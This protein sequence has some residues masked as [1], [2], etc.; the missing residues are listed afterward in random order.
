[1]AQHLHTSACARSHERETLTRCT[2]SSTTSSPVAWF[3]GT[4]P[5]NCASQLS[6]ISKQNATLALYDAST[7]T[8]YERG[9]EEISTH[10]RSDAAAAGR[11]A[12]VAEPP[13]WL[14]THQ[15]LQQMTN[16]APT[17]DF[18]ET[19]VGQ[20]DFIFGQLAGH[21]L[22]GLVDGDRDVLRL[23][24]TASRMDSDEGIVRL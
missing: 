19:L 4:D 2:A 14:C 5:R 6:I 3:T 13:A 22:E 7:S 17:F 15:Q 23:R 9:W 18:A 11:C 1:M 21:H 8:S 20:A 12:C 24:A 16:A 10:H